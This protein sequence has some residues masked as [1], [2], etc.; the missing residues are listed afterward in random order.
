VSAVIPYQQAVY[1]ISAPKLELCPADSVAE[2]AFIGRSN[3]GKSS[4]INALT[5]QHKLARTSKTPGRTQLLNFFTLAPGRYLVDVPGFGYAKVS[6]TM[7]EQWQKQLQRYLEKREPLSGL[8]LLMDIRHPFM[9]SDELMIEWCVDSAIPLHVLLTKADKLAF[10]PAKTALLQVKKRLAVR[11]DLISIQLFSAVKSQ[12]VD[13][14]RAK[15]DTW[16]SPEGTTAV[17]EAAPAIAAV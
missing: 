13:E 6:A 3:S 17:A 12:G 1:L 11:G 4:A 8:V 16:L 9:D 15:L 2:V 10:G 7:K 14:L 5:G